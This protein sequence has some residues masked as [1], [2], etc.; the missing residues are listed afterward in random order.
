MPRN[1]P[2]HALESA[3]LSGKKYKNNPFDISKREKPTLL[4]QAHKILTLCAQETCLPEKEKTREK[5]YCP[6]IAGSRFDGPWF[7]H[8]SGRWRQ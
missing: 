3:T 2:R 5:V 6:R 7:H 4:Q 8:C 1:H